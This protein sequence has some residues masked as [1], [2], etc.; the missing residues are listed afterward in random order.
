M[1]L[2]ACGASGRVSTTSPIRQTSFR[3]GVRVSAILVP[4]V[5]LLAP[6]VAVVVVTQG[7]PE[8]WFVV[9]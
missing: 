9:T 1:M 3:R 4:P 5:A 6:R 7:L 8:A 2:F